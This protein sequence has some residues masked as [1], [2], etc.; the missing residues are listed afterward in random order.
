MT[1]RSLYDFVEL[2]KKFQVYEGT[3]NYMLTDIIKILEKKNKTIHDYS[4]LTFQTPRIIRAL[5]DYKNKNPN[6]KKILTL[7]R[8]GI[9]VALKI[10]K[11]YDNP[12][13]KNEILKVT[14]SPH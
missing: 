10:Y 7:L 1:Y 14:S 6:D 9:D 5:I 13:I 11:Q 8:N 3:L 2:K 4:T 12:K